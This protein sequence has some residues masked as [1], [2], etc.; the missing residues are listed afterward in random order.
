[1]P[2]DSRRLALNGL[3]P[4]RSAIAARRRFSDMNTLHRYLLRQMVSTLVMTVIVFAFVLLLGNLLRQIVSLLVN[5]QASLFTVLEAVAYLLPFVLMY[6]LPMGLLTATLLTFGRFSADHELTAARAGGVS[7]LA[8]TTPVLLLA[9]FLSGIS[10]IISLEVAPRC[11]GAY[12][13]LLFRVGVQSVMSLIPEGRPIH[14]FENVIFYVGKVKGDNSLKDVKVLQLDREGEVVAYTQ[15]E[16]GRLEISTN[17][18]VALYLS[19]SQSSYLQ[20]GI[21]RPG[22]SGS[23]VRLQLTPEP[24]NE[25]ARPRRISDMTFS[26]LQSELR[27]LQR[28]LRASV[29]PAS[30]SVEQ[31]REMQ[32]DWEKQRDTLVS[33]ILT[34]IH[35]NLSF[36]F[37]CFSFT[38]VGIPLAIRA[39]RRE[40]SVGVAIALILALIFQGLIGLGEAMAARPELYPHLIVWSPNLLFQAVGCVLLW[41]ANRGV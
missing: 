11:Q 5:R 41:R 17:R 3:C 25:K 30:L 22:V 2:N 24:R 6:A 21:W 4:Q 12:R 9:I 15:A 18:E 27:D 31:L 35:S 39:H 10:A 37:S 1:L 20:D 32:R 40:T 28:R 26:E 7:L 8:L 14:D 34:A 36:A 19:N 23:D 13:D 38:L 33:P 16:T 29:P